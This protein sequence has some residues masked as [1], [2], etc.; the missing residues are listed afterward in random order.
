MRLDA[1]YPFRYSLAVRDRVSRYRQLV[2][3]DGSPVH[4]GGGEY[5]VVCR[6]ASS[7]RFAPEEGWEQHVHVPVLGPSSVRA[8]AFT[9]WAQEGPHQIP[10]E[11]I[12]E[13]KGRAGSLEQAGS[14]FSEL[15]RAIGNMV[16]FVAN[17][18]VGPV[19]AHLAFDSSPGKTERELLEFFLPDERGLVGEGRIIRRHLLE[20][21]CPASLSLQ[22]DSSRV[23]RA[24]RQYELGLREWYLGGE[25]LALG[26]LWIAVE[27]LTEAVLRRTKL[28][29][30]KT[31]KELAEMLDVVTDDPD[32]PRW[33]QIMR[34]QIR[35]QVI[36]DGDHETYVTAKKASDGLEHGFL[37][38]DKVARHAIAS[39]DTTFT[40]VRRTIIDLLDLPGEI[41]AELMEVK[42][43]DVQ[44]TRKI[45][46]GRLLGTAEDPAM[47]GELYPHLEWTSSIDSIAREGTAFEFKGKE[48][49]TV[50]IN[51]AIRFQ[52]DR[53]EVFGRLGEGQKPRQLSGDELN[54]SHI[55]RSRT[56]DL[57][58]AVVP[59]ADT[60]AATG[61]AVPYDAARVLAFNLYAQGVAFF[62]SAQALITGAQP[63]EALLPL[64]GLG[65]IAAR[66]EQINDPYGPGLGIAMRLALD[67][68]GAAGADDQQTG[69]AQ[70]VV[71]QVA[72]QGRITIP[73]TLP[74]P[75]GTAVYR[76]LTSEMRLAERASDGGYSIA[77]L[78]VQVDGDQAGFHTKRQPDAFTEMIASACMIA[79]LNL[80]K[81]AA[82]VFGWSLDATRA[83]ELITK[84]TE[85]ND[86]AALEDMALRSDD[87]AR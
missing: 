16:A 66:F 3:D 73:D 1:D 15:A 58:D 4:A 6:A 78:H 61:A 45:I 40:C 29:L 83:D 60:A 35:E 74:D 14:T 72:E 57:M 30:S 65:L 20:A 67:S 24:L 48:Q 81:H 79:M 82:T 25:W 21:A 64:R 5:T 85:I 52:F 49:V 62:Q 86:A 8:R 11:L 23:T 12:I 42:P 43:K 38:L 63:A 50:R 55:P 41:G 19:E 36:F 77:G 18:R 10:R 75:E 31:D 51:P 13:V 33:P 46:R 39:A 87:Q 32:R 54:L 26:H 22:A 27:N 17:V 59:L 69:Q 44:S 84:A 34:E 9:R 2:N 56:S 37:E 53:I 28:E 7:A 68:A 71:R 80:L 76:S 70:S 47:D